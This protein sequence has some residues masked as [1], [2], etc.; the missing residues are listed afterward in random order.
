MAVAVASLES[1]L[2]ESVHSG[3]FHLLSTTIA[4]PPIITEVPPVLF[5]FGETNPPFC[6]SMTTVILRDHESPPLPHCVLLAAL[7][8]KNHSHSGVP[9]TAREHPSLA[10]IGRW[11]AAATVATTATV[12]RHA[13]AGIYNHVFSYNRSQRNKCST[14]NHCCFCKQDLIGALHESFP[15]TRGAILG[16]LLKVDRLRCGFSNLKCFEIW[17]L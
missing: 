2:S 17:S 14:A 11:H 12:H 1:N 8:R 15:T 10:Q 16:K 6:Q 4:S 7:L 5:D 9:A 13:A 3:S